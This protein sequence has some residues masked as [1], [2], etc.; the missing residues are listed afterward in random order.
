MSKDNSKFEDEFYECMEMLKNEEY[1]FR[2]IPLKKLL[3]KAAKIDNRIMADH[4][5]TIKSGNWLKDYFLASNAEKENSYKKF[6][7]KVVGA[8]KRFMAENK[9]GMGG[10]KSSREVKST[11]MIDYIEEERA[12]R[13]N[14]NLINSLTVKAPNASFIK[15]KQRYSLIRRYQGTVSSCSPFIPSDQVIPSEG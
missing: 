8:R 6:I 15:C 12:K 3:I 11:Q 13:F 1:A 14:V 5:K 9:K 4:L 10:S 2:H 7:D